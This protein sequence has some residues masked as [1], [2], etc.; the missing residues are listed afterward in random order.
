MGHALAR[1]AS[2]H[3]SD[4][5]AELIAIQIQEKQPQDLKQYMI[6]LGRL[7]EL[8]AELNKRYPLQSDRDKWDAEFE[9]ACGARH[10]TKANS[11]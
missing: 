3:M 11:I 4:I 2:R 5:M 6:N 1:T 10:H 8:H 7:S 9:I